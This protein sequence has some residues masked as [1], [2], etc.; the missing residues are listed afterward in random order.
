MIPQKQST[1]VTEYHYEGKGLHTGNVSHMTLKP[2][3]ENTGILFH[4]TDLGEN[5][6]L[7]P[8]AEYI[9]S[10]SRNTTITDG[11]VSVLTLEHLM[12]ALTGM[13]VD[14]VLVELDN[15]EVPILDGSAR[16]YVEAMKRD[17]L[18]QQD[19]LRKYITL[20]KEIMAVDEKSGSWVKITPSEDVSYDATI[21]FGS[22]VLGVQEAHWDSSMDYAAEIAYCRTFVFLHEVAYLF[23][24]NLIKGGDV[25]NAIVIVEHPLPQ[26]QFEQLKSV[27]NHP[28]ISVN[29]NGYLN[30]L[31]LHFPNECSR[32]KLLDLIGDVRLCGGFIKGKVS[33]FKPGHYINSMLTKA[34]RQYILN[35]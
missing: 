26:K 33:A 31:E 19:A 29:E 17:G 10:T 12:S 30:N 9:S 3:P 11:N 8:L 13:G 27:F 16:F 24:N 23:Q 4:R 7:K 22:K 35:K 34:V 32:H 28:N 21:D 6:F 18:R 20:D 25:D 5:A 2:A 15:A 1:L 14:N